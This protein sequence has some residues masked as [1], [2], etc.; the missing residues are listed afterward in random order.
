M[1]IR[2]ACFSVVLAV[3]PSVFAGPITGA[4]GQVSAAL[5]AVRTAGGECKSTALGKLKDAR[6]HL[7]VARSK[8][9]PEGLTLARRAVEDAM[10]NATGCPADATEKM[11]TAFDGLSALLDQEAD[12]A[13]TPSPR[14]K[15]LAEKRACWNYRNDWSSVDPGCHVALNGKYA[16]GKA[17]FISARGKLSTTGDRFERMKFLEKEFG[18]RSQKLLTAWQL[19]LLIRELR[20]P[21]DQLEAVKTLA[22]R[23]VDR[24]NGHRVAKVFRD[25]RARQDALEQ[26]E[27]R[28]Y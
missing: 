25:G 2:V 10:D 17:D 24:K 1:P 6:D 12:S 15:T 27:T 3:S 7:E 18:L 13:N 5:A 8:K 19:E 22:K 9:T 21:V 14:E 28:R 20:N 11:Q 4:Q 16:I 26:F 23:V